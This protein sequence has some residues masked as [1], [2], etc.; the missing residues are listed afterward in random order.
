MADILAL[1]PKVQVEVNTQPQAIAI[2][3]DGSL[4]AIAGWDI[5][6]RKEI[7]WNDYNICW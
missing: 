1:I 7:N 3:P 4:S 6:E 2:S 5:N